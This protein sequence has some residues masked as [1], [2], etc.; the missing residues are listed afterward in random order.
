MAWSAAPSWPAMPSGPSSARS[1]R[2]CW[3]ASTSVGA[4]SAACRP[5]SITCSMARSA[6]TVL[7]AP[8]SPCTSRFIGCAADRSA[9]ISLPTSTWPAVS[10]NGSRA[11]NPSSSPPGFGGQ[12]GAGRET[13]AC[14]RSASASCTPMASSQTSRLRA[15]W[16]SASVS[17]TWIRRSARPSSVSPS[18][19]RSAAGSG[20]VGS[21]ST[22]STCRTQLPIFQDGS[23]AVAG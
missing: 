12:A 20:S 6:T 18:A 16:W 23:F 1:E 3:A 10:W 2:A 14:R 21:S 9:A 7:P 22:S 15:A 19:L 8:T 11:S 17:G 13:V 4:S 5:E